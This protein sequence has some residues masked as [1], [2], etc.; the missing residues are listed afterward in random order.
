MQCRAPTACQ[1]HQCAPPLTSPAAGERSGTAPCC[2]S[3]SVADL[4]SRR[5]EGRWLSVWPLLCD[6]VHGLCGGERPAFRGLW[7]LTTGTEDSPVPVGCS[8]AARPLPGTAA[9]VPGIS[10]SFLEFCLRDK[11][12]PQTQSENPRSGLGSLAA[13]G[14]AG[15]H[16]FQKFTENSGF[17]S[18]GFARSHRKFSVDSLKLRL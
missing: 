16:E 8:A 3:C 12:P 17:Q 7:P 18:A 11:P 4:A 15:S 13:C 5:S 14:Q 1:L 10:H 9:D 6:F 2:P